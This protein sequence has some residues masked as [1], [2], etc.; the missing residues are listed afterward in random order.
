VKKKIVIIGISLIVILLITLIN[1]VFS[2]IEKT[3]HNDKQSM[4][5]VIYYFESLSDSDYID[6]D[7]VIRF[8]A[9]YIIT[10]NDIIV[11]GPNTPLYTKLDP[12]IRNIKYQS[13]KPAYVVS[14]KNQ[15]D[16]LYKDD[17][18]IYAGFRIIKNDDKVTIS[19]IYSARR[20]LMT[21]S[22]LDELTN[23]IHTSFRIYEINSE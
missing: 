22:G 15:T 13:L 19:T 5:Y 23:I 3:I 7:R 10:N 4:T 9:N 11:F 20:K 2:H 1:I 21:F 12:M 17:M 6:H 18:N 8:A 14:I 16:I